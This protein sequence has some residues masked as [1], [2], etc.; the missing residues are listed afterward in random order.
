MAGLSLI[1]GFNGFDRQQEQVIERTG[2]LHGRAICTMRTDILVKPGD[3]RFHRL[4]SCGVADL[5]DVGQ[6]QLNTASLALRSTRG[7]A[8]RLFDTPTTDVV[9]NFGQVF[10]EFG[11][12]IH[13]LDP[14]RFPE[15]LV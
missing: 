14:P 4:A 13:D 2:T 1:D 7:R 12:R 9:S 10:V 8:R 6:V 3:V 5:N 15:H 11:L